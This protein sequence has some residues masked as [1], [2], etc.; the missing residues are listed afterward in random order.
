MIRFTK[1]SKIYK[2]VK[3]TRL[4]RL[5][6]ILKT[7]KKIINRIKEMVH[8][9]TGLERIAFFVL[10][11]FIICHS[12]GCAWIFVARMNYDPDDTTAD[13]ISNNGYE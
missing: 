2:L 9:R 10:L 1:I 3:I 4:V 7:R 11:L 5:V 12:I 6:K 8:F 13:W